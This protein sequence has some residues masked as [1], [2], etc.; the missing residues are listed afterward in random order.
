MEQLRRYLNGELLV[1]SYVIRVGE[2]LVAVDP[3]PS[4]TYGGERFDAVLCTHIHLDHCGSAGAYRGR[5]Y[6]H[7]KYAAYLADPSLLD[8]LWSSSRQVLGIWAEK[9][10]R[11]ELAGSVE[12]VGDNATILDR[13]VAIHT[14]GHA[15]HHVMYLDKD[16]GTLFV[17]DGAGVYVPEANSVIPTTPPPFLASKYLDSIRKALSYGPTRLCYPH[18]GCVDDV[19][20]ARVHMEQVRLWLEEAS[21]ATGEEDLLARLLRSDEMLARAWNVGGPII[22]EFIIKPSLRGFLTTAKS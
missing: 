10:G 4:S 2:G 17:G 19:E 8:K 14:P 5:V 16:E 12:P 3:G 20:L 11:P 18:F 6:V 15:P 1:V 13:F 21:M 22:R 9:M 7:E